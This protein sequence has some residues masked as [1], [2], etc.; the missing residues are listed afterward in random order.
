M[1]AIVLVGVAAVAF[2]AGRTIVPAS[3]TNRRRLEPPGA[4]GRW[5]QDGRQ[6][7]GQGQDDNGLGRATTARARDVASDGQG[8]RDGAGRMDQG[9]QGP[10]GGGMLPGASLDPNGNGRMPAATP[11]VT[12]EARGRSRV[13]ASDGRACAAST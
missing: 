8:Q 13:P 12:S 5:A 7:Q 10:M 4:A 2:A 3:D 1:G 9:G 11:T 6:G